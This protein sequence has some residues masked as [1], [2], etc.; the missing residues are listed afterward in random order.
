MARRVVTA[1]LL[2]VS[3]ASACAPRALLERA[4]RAR[5]GA[6]PGLVRDVDAT[7][8]AEY[9]GTWSATET[10]QRPERFA[11]TIETFGEPNHYLFDGEAVRAFIGTA[12]VSTDTDPGAPLRTHARFMAV[13]LLDVLGEPGVTVEDLPKERLP[14]GTTSGLACRFPDETEFV[15]GFDADARLVSVDGPLDLPGAGVVRVQAELSEYVRVAAWSLPTRIR[16]RMGDRLLIDERARALCP[17]PPAL[18][19][20]AFRDPSRLPP[21]ERRIVPE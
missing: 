9:P 15:L 13:I 20:E 10:F 19:I 18:T 12:L 11:W 2:V 16:Y 7:L 14:M 5:G 1:A 4:I 17:D 21:C 6:L 8:T 3:T